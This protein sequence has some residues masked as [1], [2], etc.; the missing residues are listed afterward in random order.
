MTNAFI[1]H[2]DDG[3]E[4]K[5]EN[6]GGKG[7]SLVTMTAAGM[8]VPPGFVITTSAFDTFVDK[9][10]ITQINELLEGVDVDDAGIAVIIKAP[11]LI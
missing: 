11:K 7:A 5:L 2:F 10:L 4:P 1:E 8:P 6:L 3:I 9:E